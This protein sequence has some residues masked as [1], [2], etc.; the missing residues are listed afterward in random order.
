MPIY[1]DE[2]GTVVELGKLDVGFRTG[3]LYE[4]NLF[5]L[6]QF[7]E[8]KK[9]SELECYPTDADFRYDR[10]T[11]L[12]AFPR[13]NPQAVDTLIKAIITFREKYYGRRNTVSEAKDEGLLSCKPSPKREIHYTIGWKHSWEPFIDKNIGKKILNGCQMFRTKKEA[14]KAIGKDE[15]SAVYGVYCDWEKDVV[16]SPSGS[17]YVLNNASEACRLTK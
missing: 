15:N 11:S 6:M 12:I 8:A 5:C 17:Y 10:A 4:K 16:L 3:Q 14:I 2:F 7:K 13:D 9:Q 1:E